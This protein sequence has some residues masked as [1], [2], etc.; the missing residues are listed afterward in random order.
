MENETRADGNRGNRVKELADRE[1]YRTRPTFVS[2][3][4]SRCL[5]GAVGQTC[6]SDTILSRVTAKSKRFHEFGGRGKL[7]GNR[8]GGKLC[9][10]V[11]CERSEAGFSP[12]DFITPRDGCESNFNC[13]KFRDRLTPALF[14]LFFFFLFDRAIGTCG[15]SEW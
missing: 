4:I 11:F 8:S 1:L 15:L 12:N 2:T 13:L 6:G 9:R 5:G 7:E 3:E 14:F 10:F